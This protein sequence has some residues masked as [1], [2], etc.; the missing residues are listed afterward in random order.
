MGGAGHLAAHRGA[1]SE[2]RERGCLSPVVVSVLPG[3][4]EENVWAVVT[5]MVRTSEGLCE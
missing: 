1:F 4:A 3:K 5:L 2:R